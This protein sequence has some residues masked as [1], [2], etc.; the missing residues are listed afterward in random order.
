MSAKRLKRLTGVPVMPAAARPASQ[1]AR[2]GQRR[3]EPKPCAKELHEHESEHGES[4][5]DEPRETEAEGRE[6]LPEV[7]PAVEPVNAVDPG[8]SRGGSRGRILSGRERHG[9]EDHDALGRAGNERAVVVAQR[10][11]QP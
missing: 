7:G 10:A 9:H 6:E 1:A 5:G 2:D 8:R 11:S 4:C 3:D